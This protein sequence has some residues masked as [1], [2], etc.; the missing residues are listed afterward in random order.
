MK[1]NILADN[2]ADEKFASRE[3]FEDE[4]SQFSV[5][6]DEGLYKRGTMKFSQNCNKLLNKSVHIWP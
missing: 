5:N 2:S 3:A 4:R 1:N 6:M